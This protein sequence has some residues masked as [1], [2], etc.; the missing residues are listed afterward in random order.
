MKKR[1]EIIEKITFRHYYSEHNVDQKR[2]LKNALSKFITVSHFYACMRNNKYT[3]L[4]RKEIE[5]ITNLE[6]NWNDEAE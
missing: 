3:P 5:S 4:L 6:F 2:D 1:A